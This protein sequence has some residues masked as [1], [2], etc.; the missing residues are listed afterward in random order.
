[1]SSALQTLQDKI[2]PIAQNTDEN[3]SQIQGTL[4]SMNAL[5]QTAQTMLTAVDDINV[6]IASIAEDIRG[7]EQILKEISSISSQ[8]NILAINASIE[9][10]RAGATGKGFAVVAN[11]VRSLA[12]KSSSTVQRAK[13]YTER[14]EQSIE[15]INDNVANIVAKANETANNATSMVGILDQTSNH[16]A[17][18]TKNIQEIS[19]ITEEINAS[20]SQLIN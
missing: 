10:S 19:A 1:M 5:T 16:S 7:Y 11:E 4:S 9:A 17:D 14:I 18:V 15:S 3:L 20:M 2:S 8:T 6:S 13:E 12:T